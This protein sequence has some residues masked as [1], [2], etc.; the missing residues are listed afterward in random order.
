MRGL[1]MLKE[2]NIRKRILNEEQFEN[3][4]NACSTHIRPVVLTAHYLARRRSEILFLTWDE[5]DLKEGF[6]RLRADRTKTK[7]ARSI[8]IHPRIRAMLGKLPRGIHTARVFL[9]NGRPFDDIKKSFR[10]ACKKASLEDFTFHDLRHCAI[11]AL[12]LTGND[13]FKTM[14]VSGHKTMSV[15]KRY[16]LVTEAE[17][18]E[19]SW[20]DQGNAME[21]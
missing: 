9:M 3:L 7:V 10:S 21:Q 13:Y 17:L 14:A 1:K 11:N 8:P 12:R 16:N 15:F 5:V 2:N 20:F 4:L 18:S 6:V 19:I